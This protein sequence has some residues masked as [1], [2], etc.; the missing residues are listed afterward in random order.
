MIKDLERFKKHAESIHNCQ[1]CPLH[2]TC[3]KKM[4][5]AG[6]PGGYI[7]VVMEAPRR[8]EIQYQRPLCYDAGLYLQKC[9]IQAGFEAGDCLITYCVSC[10]LPEIRV[11]TTEE[12][13]A[14]FGHLWKTIEYFDPKLIIPVGQTPTEVLCKSKKS[15]SALQG[16]FTKLGPYRVMPLQHPGF[17]KAKGT[18][19]QVKAYVQALKSARDLVFA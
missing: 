14:C 10:Q 2:L 13:G 7:L 15:V 5:A 1:R 8:E 19:I 18:R 17:I 3:E 6:N 12:C 11:P 16:S 4:V 9:M